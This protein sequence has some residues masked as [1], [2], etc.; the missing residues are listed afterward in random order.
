MGKPMGQHSH[1]RYIIPNP[2]KGPKRG[3]DPMIS[4]SSCAPPSTACRSPKIRS[5]MTKNPQNLVKGQHT[6]CTF[7]EAGNASMYAT[8]PILSNISNGPQNLATIF[9]QL[10]NFKQIF[11][12]FAFKSVNFSKSHPVSVSLIFQSNLIAKLSFSTV[13]AYVTA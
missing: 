11:L 9:V 10:P 1:T 5:N 13:S 3:R 4:A 8:G 12:G 6:L 7:M 2:K